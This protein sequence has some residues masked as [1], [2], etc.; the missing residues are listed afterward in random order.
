MG[1]T[2]TIERIMAAADLGQE[3][4]NADYLLESGAVL[5][6]V[7]GASLVYKVRRL[8]ENPQEL[9]AMRARTK[10]VARPHAAS[11]AIDAVARGVL[12]SRI[13]RRTPAVVD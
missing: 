1:F 12:T 3:E 6:A 5:T 7:D 10:S 9:Q 2:R 11:S 8:V 4:R 13:S